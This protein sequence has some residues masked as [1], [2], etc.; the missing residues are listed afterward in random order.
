M[1]ELLLKLFKLYGFN[2]IINNEII[3]PSVITY[4]IK[5]S[6]GTKLATLN[7][8]LQ[9]IARDAGLNSI[10][11]VKEQGKLFLEVSNESPK[12]VL[13]TNIIKHDSFRHSGQYDI[14]MGINT[15]NKLTFANLRKLPHL[16]IGGSTGSGKSVGIHMLLCSLLAKN[17]PETLQIML[18]DPKKTELGMYDKVPHLLTNVITNAE[19]AAT[20]LNLMVIEMEQRYQTMQQHNAREMLPDMPVILIVIDEMADLMLSGV[21]DLETNLIRLAQK[22]RACG[23]HI[24]AATQRPSREVVTGLIKANFPARLA[25]KTASA[26]DS[27]VILD[28]KGAELLLGQGDS[29]YYNS[30]RL[31]R[32]KATF[33]DD[34]T[35]AHVIEAVSHY[36]PLKHK[37]ILD[38][39]TSIENNKEPF[40]KA[41]QRMLRRKN[42]K[43]KSITLALWGLFI[44]TSI[45]MIKSVVKFIFS[46]VKGYT[47]K[48]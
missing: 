44:Y 38:N 11:L 22:A 29:L 5:L 1:K 41:E 28:S 16:L 33:M 39:N 24:I 46:P 10:R 9:D 12:T 25:Y 18:I 3:S 19:A 15:H 26:I 14:L 30:G 8:V 27:R 20:A 17:S 13:F 48:R 21:D 31:Q 34:E 2:I 36:N 7:A 45:K 6:H 23:I 43:S 37:I 47:P 35:L 42:I 4:E 32:V 40:T